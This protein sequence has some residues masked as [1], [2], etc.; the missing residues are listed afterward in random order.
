MPVEIQIQHLNQCTALMQQWNDLYSGVLSVEQQM[1]F[2]KGTL[3]F[4]SDSEN[5]K[6][7]MLHKVGVLEE[8][9]R[10]LQF[11]GIEAEVADEKTGGHE[12]YRVR[13]L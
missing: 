12:E 8:G 9:K 5:L 11:E 6:Y 10:N 3:S 4:G 1:D 13:M 2:E 7:Q